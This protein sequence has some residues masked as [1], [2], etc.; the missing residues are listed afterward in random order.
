[1]NHEPLNTMRFF[2]F[3]SRETDPGI[4]QT[5]AGTLL[6]NL[7][8]KQHFDQDLV[9]KLE[10]KQQ[11][12]H[13]SKHKEKQ[14]FVR[15]LVPKL[16]E[17]QSFDQDLVSKLKK[18]RLLSGTLLKSP[19]K[20]VLLTG[21]LVQNLRESAVFM[22]VPSTLYVWYRA[23]EPST[24]HMSA[25]GLPKGSLGIQ[26]D[27]LQPARRHLFPRYCYSMTKLNISRARCRNSKDDER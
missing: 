2:F 27:L 18:N 26:S 21:T 10:E 14:H 15:D 5:W 6:Q 9:P 1:M 23:P 11:I 13:F 16:N 25:S 8:E 20:N 12:D 24:P 17:K 3:H 19:R 7:K 22:Q 4:F